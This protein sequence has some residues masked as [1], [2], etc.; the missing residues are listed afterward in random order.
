MRIKS[1]TILCSLFFILSFSSNAIAQR[2]ELVLQTGHSIAVRTVAFSPNRKILAS[3]GREGTIKLWNLV[4]GTE[5]RS[6]KGHTKA[7][8]S[9]TEKRDSSYTST[10][11]RSSYLSCMRA[12]TQ[13]RR[14][15]SSQIRR[16]SRICHQPGPRCSANVKKRPRCRQ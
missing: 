12:P 15:M 2:P 13:F 8:S 10:T 7:L 3:A 1:L 14:S 4:D 9:S 11:N 5:L 6:L 16:N